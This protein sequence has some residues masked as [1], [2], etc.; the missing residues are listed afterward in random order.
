MLPVAADECPKFCHEKMITPS[1][2][3]DLLGVVVTGDFG[4]V[5]HFVGYPTE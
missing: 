1:E 3:E 4:I 2:T 5:P